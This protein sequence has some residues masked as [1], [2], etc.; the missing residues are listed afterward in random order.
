MTL[1]AKSP[2]LT[3]TERVEALKQFQE[4]QNKVKQKDI[5]SLYKMI[6]PTVYRTGY[7]ASGEKGPEFCLAGGSNN[8]KMTEKEAMQCKDN[9][10]KN[11]NDLLQVTVDLKK[12]ILMPAKLD[13]A[14][15]L[16][17]REISGGFKYTA[18]DPVW[19]QRKLG[20]IVRASDDY[21]PKNKSSFEDGCVQTA[22]Y[23]F[24]FKNSKLKLVYTQ[25]LP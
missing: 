6:D 18:D 24:E 10:I 17:V 23:F 12:Q 19:L 11:L 21:N 8:T 22:S 3:Q 4:F 5:K 7:L 20:L 1:Y 14:K 15:R 2:E 16:C 9:I 13:G 25:Y